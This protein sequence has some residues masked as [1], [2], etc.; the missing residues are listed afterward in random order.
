[1]FKEGINIVQLDQGEIIQVGDKHDIAK[2]IEKFYTKNPF[3][4]YND[5]ETILDLI[6]TVEQNQF[7]VNLKKS[8]GL[9]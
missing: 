6:N 9:Y 5:F 2:L 3:P 7:T 1:M 8:I 4:D